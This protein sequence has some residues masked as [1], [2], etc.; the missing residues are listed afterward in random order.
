MPLILDRPRVL[1]AYADAAQNQWVLPAFNT[2]N[3]TTTEAILASAAD[4]A[5]HIGR[6][7]M[8]IIV[9]ITNRYAHRRNPSST[10]TRASGKWAC[11]CSWTT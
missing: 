5:A 9:G 3:Q 1:A 11:G 8:P 6:P 4:Y 2:E 10:P 7:D